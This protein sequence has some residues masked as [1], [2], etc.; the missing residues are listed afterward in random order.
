VSRKGVIA[1]LVLL[2]G[3][4][5]WPLSRPG[6]W[7]AHDMFHHLFRVVDLSIVLRGGVLYARWLPDLGFFYGYP[8]LNF[9][10]PLTYYL[11]LVFHWL[12]SSYI[13]AMKG[14]FALSF[15]LAALGAYAWA[16]THWSREA[17]VWVAVMYTLLPYHLANAYVR[18]ALAEHWAQAFMPWVL[19]GIERSREDAARGRGAGDFKAWGLRFDVRLS[20]FLL[21][22]LLTHNLSAF[23]FF[24]VAF[25]YALARGYGLH[26]RKPYIWVVML[27]FVFAVGV[28]AFYW[29][30][31]LAEVSWIRAGQ[32]GRYVTQQVSQ[33]ASWRSLL[34][35]YVV[36]RYY[37][38]Q[39]VP[40]E[41]PLAGWSVL[42]VGCGMVLAGRWRVRLTADQ[43]S[44]LGTAGVLLVLALFLM[45]A[46]SAFL[47]KHVHA[48]AFLQF[49][50]RLQTVVSITAAL[51][52]APVV[53]LGLSPL[54]TRL[55]PRTRLPIVYATGLGFVVVLALLTMPHLPRERLAW[56]DGRVVQEADLSFW[57]MAQY[58]Y[59]NGLFARE[60]G[61][62]WL[63]EYLPT[64]VRVPREE[65]WLP[66]A[67]DSPWVVEPYTRPNRVT[68][69][70]VCPTRFVLDVEASDATFVR[71]HQFW[72]PGWH[73]RVDGQKVPV[74]PSPNL[75]LI[76]VPVPAG[77]H[78]VE[79]FFGSTAPR[80]WGWALAGV[81]L[82]WGVVALWRQ[83][84]Y[85]AL[86]VPLALVLVFVGLWSWQNHRAPTCVE[87]QHAWLAV[88]SREEMAFLGC[89]WYNTA[90]PTRDVW[91][92]VVYWFAVD[93]P[94]EDVK[95]FV[96]LLDANGRV[97][98]QHDAYPG[99]NFSPTSRWEVGE[100]VPDYH[101]VSGSWVKGGERPSRVRTGMYRYTDHV[102]NL[103]VRTWVGED[104][105]TMWEGVCR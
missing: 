11:T 27:S 46:P 29:L 84:A 83:R 22:L 10:A 57:G 54:W 102:E 35:P 78:R 39:G 23:L 101:T 76:T 8:V 70:R 2:L 99:E 100:I 50:W 24:P 93:S 44:M 89:A 98:G 53:D 13:L 94:A 32:V 79:I 4:V 31:A 96:H 37:P 6:L 91:S 97:L 52:V 16:R 30:P 45:L 62:P 41:H 20:V 21:A 40:F 19:W 58:D 7:A 59:I 105:G 72:F 82:A 60:H 88:G 95:S 103:P 38:Y 9:Y 68:L 73:A 87:P 33:L 28:S 56:P 15:L 86:M 43:R 74:R 77:H 71:W 34:S 49:P 61:D 42:I 67:P 26:Q 1:S 55:P 12:G 36:Y 90:S 18:G 25:L 51:F 85:Y 65:F 69:L 47:W 80:Q 5:L 14:S 17:A 104:R 3:V 66:R 48:L 75:G 81:A 63:M 92:V 64:T